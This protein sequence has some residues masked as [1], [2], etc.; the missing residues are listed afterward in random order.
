MRV[1]AEKSLR[2]RVGYE[3]GSDREHTLHLGGLE[4]PLGAFPVAVDVGGHFQRGVAE[5]SG[6]PGD[7]GPALE[8]SLR[9]G[10]SEAVK[11]PQFLRRP[12]TLDP[13]SD[14]KSVV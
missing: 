9:E 5:V 4:L 2:V 12:G 3:P 13:P 1:T 10:V 14:R 6:E 11:C 8:R 7:L